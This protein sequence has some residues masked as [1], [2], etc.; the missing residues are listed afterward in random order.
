MNNFIQI[1]KEHDFVILEI[2]AIPQAIARRMEMGNYKPIVRFF[3]WTVISEIF[4]A[5]PKNWVWNTWT[6]KYSKEKGPFNQVNIKVSD[7]M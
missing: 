4:Q 6:G 2:V 5:H 3:I 1:V 7:D